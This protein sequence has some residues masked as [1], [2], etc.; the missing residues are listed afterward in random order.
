MGLWCVD[1]WPLWLSKQCCEVCGTISAV[2]Q[3]SLLLGMLLFQH[4][5]VSVFVF[6]AGSLCHCAPGQAALWY[7][8]LYLLY[9]AA[10]PAVRGAVVSVCARAS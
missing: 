6:V 9:V 8:L 7:L 3:H 10:L 1:V 4:V 5:A 2:R